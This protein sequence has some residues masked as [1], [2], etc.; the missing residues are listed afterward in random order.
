VVCD[1][2]SGR[3]SQCNAVHRALRLYYHGLAPMMPGTPDA[4][5]DVVTAEYVCRAVAALALRD[6]AIGRTYHLC[7]GDAALP[8]E[9]LLDLTYEVWRADTRWRRRAVARPVVTDLATYELF[10]ASVDEVADR[11]LKQVLRSLSH[12]VPQLALPK[13]FDT[14]LAD[15][16]VG[17][18]APRPESYW[19][20][21]VQQLARGDWTAARPTAA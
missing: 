9:R 14:T 17:R 15:A 5:V 8:L 11:R 1:D 6:D 4:A 10:E 3:V 13:C 16:G 21:M 20:R 19:R 18:P 12:F 2:A 7:A